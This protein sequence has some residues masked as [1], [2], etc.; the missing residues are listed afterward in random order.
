MDKE[1]R[2]ELIRDIFNRTRGKRKELPFELQELLQE[3]R[4]EAVEFAQP[5]TVIEFQDEDVWD[6][7]QFLDGFRR[8]ASEVHDGDWDSLR[9]IGSGSTPKAPHWERYAVAN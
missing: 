9:L 3:L 8:Q 2:L 1:T 5:A 6:E 4:E 7:V